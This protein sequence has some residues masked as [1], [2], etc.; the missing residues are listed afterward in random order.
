MGST[1]EFETPKPSSLLKVVLEMASVE[2]DLVIDFFAGSGTF[3][4]AVLERPDDNQKRQFI[5]VQL[6]QN[7]PIDDPVREAGFPT[8]SDITIQ[9]VK[10]VIQ[11]YGENPQ[12]IPDSG[13]RVFKLAKSNFPRCEFVPDPKLSEA[14]NVEALKRY[15][16][17]KE[18]AYLLPLD[19]GAERAVFD[20]VLLKCGFQLHYSRRRREDFT[21]NSVYEVSDGQR[22]ALVCLAWNE[23]IK[24]ATL[25]RL[26]E[27]DESEKRFFI[28]L[29][30]SLSTTT[31][32]NLD[33][34]LGKRLTAF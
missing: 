6:P 18:T 4:H 32:W 11:G 14:E 7:V 23:G 2:G 1:I 33:H 9:R 29:E 20:E 17:D 31:K 15:I 19:A 27:L 30:R 34:L 21:D 3:A 13:F 28:C 25:K 12:P 8:I 16:Q 5:L 10:R 22:R 24:D 26:R